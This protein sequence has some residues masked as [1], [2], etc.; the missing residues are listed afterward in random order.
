MLCAKA[1]PLQ[2]AAINAAASK[3]MKRR[4]MSASTF[5]SGAG[6]AHMNVIQPKGVEA[7]L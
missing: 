4:C 2:T 7:I 1:W 5:V 3:A 6:L